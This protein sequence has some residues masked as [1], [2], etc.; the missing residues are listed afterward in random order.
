MGLDA[1]LNSWSWG[2]KE[3]LILCLLSMW[4]SPYVREL[5]LWKKNRVRIFSGNHNTVTWVYK[6]L[7]CCCC[8]CCLVAKL[9]PTLCDPMDSKFPCPSPSSGVSSNSCPLSQ[10]CQP[11]ISSSVTPFFS[12]LHS[13]PASRAFP[14]SWLLTSDS[15]IIGA[16]ALASVLPVN[17][18]GWFP[19]GLTG[20]ISLQ[21]KGLSGVFSNTIVQKHQFFSAQPSSWSNSYICTWLLEKP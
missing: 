20:L 2:K 21:T 1:S 5:M 16:S 12:H 13:F 6:E 8:C 10:W 7:C 9:C 19:F 4:L 11:T 15:Q 14:V 17:I 18:Q 3:C